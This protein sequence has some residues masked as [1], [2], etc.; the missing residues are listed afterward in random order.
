ME[1]LVFS[2]CLVALAVDSLVSGCGLFQFLVQFDVFVLDFILLND[3]L[4]L[5]LFRCCKQFLLLG[6]FALKLLDF[7]LGQSQFLSPLTELLLLGL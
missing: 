6:E 5:S 4:D 7:L 2:D 3:Q 1:N